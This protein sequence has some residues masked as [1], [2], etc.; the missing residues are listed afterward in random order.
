MKNQNDNTDVLLDDEFKSKKTDLLLVHPS[1]IVVVGN[2]I[3]M[4]M[5]DL[6]LLAK[7]ISEIG[8]QV[9]LKAK[10]VRGEDKW[11]LVD[12]HRRFAA[13][14]ILIKQGVDLKIPIIPFS[15]NNEDR[16]I[17]MLATGIGQKELTAV[18][19]S[20][21]I[22]KLV[23]LSFS[24][25]EIALKIGKSVQYMYHLLKLSEAPKEVKVLL[26]QNK[27]SSGVVVD[28]IRQ[29]E[30]EEQQVEMVKRVIEVANE[31]GK[32][33][34]TGKHLE[35]KVTPIQKFTQ[36]ADRITQEE[37]KNEKMELFLSLFTEIKKEK[38]VEELMELFQ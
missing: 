19:Q 6:D 1:N 38:S 28:I 8:I 7:S 24:V 31:Q 29:A 4:D 9:P 15:G 37:D 16:L 36:L 25:E 14:S 32:T 33:K 17:T 11:E 21:G 2:N 26:A 23:A 3:R 30:N 34:A 13:I 5:G 35:K 20:E 27:V 10:K 12:G 22:K 18:E